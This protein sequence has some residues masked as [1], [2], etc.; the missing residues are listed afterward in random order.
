[1]TGAEEKRQRKFRTEKK[2]ERKKVTGEPKM[3]FIDSEREKRS[4][5]AF[6]DS[7]LQ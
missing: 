3:S 4:K 5:A 7:G 1:M 2:K 6:G